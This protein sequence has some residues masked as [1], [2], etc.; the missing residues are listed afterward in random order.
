MNYAISVELQFFLI[1]VLWGV[2]LLLVYDVLRILRRVVKHDGFF[3]ALE[4]LIFWVCASLFIFIMMYKENNGVIRG[5][6][7]MGMAI[8]TIIYHFT[9]SEFFV[10]IVTKIIHT[11]LSPLVFIIKQFIKTGKLVI[12]KAKK[13]INHLNNRLKKRIQSVKM[14]VAEKQQITMKKRQK[15]LE[16][17]KLKKKRL[18]DIQQAKKKRADDIKLA[19]RKRA[20][21]IRQPKS[22]TEAKKSQS[23][24]PLQESKNRQA[25]EHGTS[26]ITRVNSESVKNK[27]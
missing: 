13:V 16:E 4:D 22:K 10:D 9:I 2:L 19:K 7:I 26:Q 17:K 21:D 8:G 11:L 24:K 18:D 14:K 5:F 1:S 27:R 20:V 15:I 12:G 3:I 25:V 23:N 6:S